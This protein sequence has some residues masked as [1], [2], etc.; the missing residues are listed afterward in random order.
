[1]ASCMSHISLPLPSQTSV[2]GRKAFPLAMFVRS[3]WRMSWTV[4]F[5]PALV[6]P[7]KDVVDPVTPISPP[8][9]M[10]LYPPVFHA[11]L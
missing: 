9:F 2:H 10:L 7:A 3:V 1:M 11:R 6:W 5:V 8:W 4:S